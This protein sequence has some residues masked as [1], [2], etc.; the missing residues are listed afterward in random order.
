MVT[1]ADSTMER[2][3]TSRVSGSVSAD[4]R[5]SKLNAEPMICPSLTR[6]LMYS[7]RPS[8][9]KISVQVISP[10]GRL[11]NASNILA[12]ERRGV[13]V[14]GTLMSALASA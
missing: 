3:S 10:P 1:M 7:S 13:C 2:S 11:S 12:R 8:A 4:H 9:N 6:T 5:L 14:A